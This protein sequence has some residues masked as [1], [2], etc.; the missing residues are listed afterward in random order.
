[1]AP[2]NKAG[3]TLR[4][5]VAGTLLLVGAVWFWYHLCGNPLH[6]LA[7]IRRA[8]VT[9]GTLVDTYEHEQEDFRGHVYFSDVG[10]YAFR[11]PDGREFK[12]LMRVPIGSLEQHK[13][14]EYLPDAPSVNRVAGE[15]C[16]TIFEWLWRKIGLGALLFVI[17]VSPGVFVLLNWYPW[18]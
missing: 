10:V 17:L 12:A 6:E 13:E 16:R 14:V 2:D 5:L 9:V 7:L 8:Q 4:R 11:V 1:M 15:G 3:G 18:D